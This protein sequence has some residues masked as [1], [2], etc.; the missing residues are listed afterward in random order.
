MSEMSKSP[1]DLLLDQIRAVV[2][3]ELRTASNGNGHLPKLLYNT[4]EAARLCDIP[5]SWLASAARSGK[6]KCRHLGNYVRF[7]LEDLKE[8][9]EKSGGET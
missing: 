9:I 5:E 6:V 2:R 4:K 7:T 8:F 3:E 1:F